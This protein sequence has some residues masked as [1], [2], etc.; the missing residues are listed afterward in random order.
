MEAE[1][2][3]PVIYEKEPLGDARE[4]AGRRIRDAAEMFLFTGSR[5]LA[6]GWLTVVG[7]LAGVFGGT[8][9]SGA[10][11][12]PIWPVL[13]WLAALPLGWLGMRRLSE[14]MFGPAIRWQAVLAFFWAFL[15]SMAAVGAGQIGSRNW[16]YGLSLGAGLFIGLPFGATEPHN[17]KARDSWLML[18]LLLA[19][20]STVAGTYAFRHMPGFAPLEAAALAGALCALIIT[21]PMMALLVTYW[22]TEK[23]IEKVVA[24]C[25]EHEAY[26]SVA[27]SYL[28]A[29]IRSAPANAT[30]YGLRAVAHSRAG[31]EVRAEEDWQRV[32]QLEPD[33]VEPYLVRGNDLL[34]RGRADEAMASFEKAAQLAPRK[35]RPQYFLGI[36]HLKLGHPE[37]AIELLDTAIAR[38]PKLAG[39]YARRAEAHLELRRPQEAVDDSTR[40]IQIDP[41][42]ARAYLTRGRAYRALGRHEEADEDFQSAWD[43][44]SEDEME[45][46]ARRLEE[47]GRKPE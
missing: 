15:L 8:I 45:D 2:E 39:A 12:R 25:L 29:G 11:W 22:D 37:R 4:A 30:L 34:K 27:I 40:A 26:T 14:A 13:L 36:A 3:G 5:P 44:G 47:Q 28:N 23:G 43:S 16:S 1:D 42:N 7:V 35:A 31:D 6:A 38:S 17:F 19:G 33:S 20:T 32:F 41:A 9:V 46:A 21:A 24:L 10:L 18:G